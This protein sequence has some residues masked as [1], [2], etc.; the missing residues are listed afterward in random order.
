MVSDIGIMQTARQLI[1]IDKP[2]DGFT[3][4]WELGRLDLSLE[5]QTLN[6]IYKPL[7]TDNERQIC[8]TRLEEYGY[9]V[10]RE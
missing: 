3:I 10:I 5:V 7:F 2:S 8:I 1:N 9:N 4:L 6:P